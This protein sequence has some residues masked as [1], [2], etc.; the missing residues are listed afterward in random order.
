MILTRA[1][2]RGATLAGGA[3]LALFATIGGCVDLPGP[4]S[5]S[6][7]SSAGLPARC[8]RGIDGDT[9]EVE[10]RDY[11]TLTVRLVD[12]DTPEL[13]TPEAWAAA[14]YSA[15]WLHCGAVAGWP[16]EVHPAGVDPYGR[17]LASITRRGANLGTELL[18]RGHAEVYR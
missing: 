16:F 18:A 4:S 12:V 17:Q 10:V 7:P 9:F 6:S 5:S 14:D 2:K 11:G 3:A 8:V 13:P 1:Q 15:A